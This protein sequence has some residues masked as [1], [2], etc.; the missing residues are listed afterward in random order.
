MFKVETL[1]LLQL[2][3]VYLY[4]FASMLV[5]QLLK[6]IRIK[7][8]KG[9]KIYWILA[10]MSMKK[11]R[12]LI[13]FTALLV[14]ALWKFDVVLDV[15]RTIWNI[16]FP[17]A[18]GGAIAF[19]INVPMSFLEKKLFDKSKKSNK[20]GRKTGKTGQ[21]HSYC[22]VTVWCDR[23]SDAWRG[24]TAD[25]DHGKPDAE[26]RGFYSGAAELGPGIFS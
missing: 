9:G 20:T 16:V 12:E 22:G 8:R 10:N 13:V 6:W 15:I 7:L 14:V 11:L 21:S 24:S 2:G 17:F 4:A 5:I 19:V 18:L 23:L 26:Y 3:F 25:T 1:D